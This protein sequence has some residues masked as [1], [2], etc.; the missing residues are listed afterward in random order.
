MSFSFLLDCAKENGQLGYGSLLASFYS[1][2]KGVFSE[3]VFLLF[4]HTLL[5]VA[6][7][8]QCKEVAD[9]STLNYFGCP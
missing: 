3:T 4:S 1:E 8:D 9:P 6:P 7:R 2:F 5:L